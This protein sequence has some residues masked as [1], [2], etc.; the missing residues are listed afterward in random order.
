L[1]KHFL[2]GALFGGGGFF[3][4]A[5]LNFILIGAITRSL[6]K[7]L[8]GYYFFL[9]TLSE[10]L[11]TIDMGTT[12]GLVHNLSGFY[13]LNDREKISEQLMLGKVLYSLIA[14]AIFILGL[15]VSP[16]INGL[17]H[18]PQSL[19]GIAQTCIS[20]IFAE[21]S[22][23]MLGC[24]F[25]SIIISQCRYKWINSIDTI[26]ICLTTGI[27]I[28]SLLSKG[29]LVDFLFIRLGISVVKNLLLLCKA[30]QYEKEILSF[31]GK[32]KLSALKQLF[33]ISF[34]AMIRQLS[35]NIAHKTDDFVIGTFL[36]VSS[37]G[38]Y[39]LVFRI[40]GQV[41]NFC[42][43]ITE[44]A[45]PLF[46]KLSIKKDT[47]ESRYIF[48]S[49]STFLNY[50]ACMAIFFF[51]FFYDELFNLLAAGTF[52]K[53]ETLPIVMIAVPTI[54]SGC[55]QMPASNYLFASGHHKYLTK[56]SLITAITNFILTLVLVKPLGLPGVALGTLI[57]HFIQHQV[58]SIYVSCKKLGI[59]YATY[60][61]KVY[62]N[63]L[64]PILLFIGLV[65]GAKQA[66]QLTNS[67]IFVLAFLIGI[68]ALLSLSLWLYS[69]LTAEQLKKVQSAL[70]ARFMKTKN[71]SQDLKGVQDE[72][73]I[74]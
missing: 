51:L 61:K 14:I 32:L 72:L 62:V 68:A 48:L 27:G 17:F 56:S 44:G 28:V 15:T 50:F 60:L 23:N 35:V 9:L 58:F 47:E 66:Y 71:N 59:P 73:P 52:S 55:M 20:L 7:E 21:A 33:S 63:N 38:I 40:F 24:Y 18:L 1:K 43:K 37:I 30:W 25:Q 57:P 34:H 16:Y 19:N 4:K 54:W 74:S 70:F 22:I 49:I 29:S 45:F 12:T 8:G 67:N 3:V 39:G 64:L 10:I 26:S 11:L 46:A 13:Q 69:F 5:I 42:V 36:N 2:E 6:G 41:G 65:I 53:A 31:S